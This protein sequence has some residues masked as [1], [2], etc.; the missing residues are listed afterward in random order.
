MT[1]QCV[2]LRTVLNISL[3]R[4]LLVDTL[5]SNA[6]CAPWMAAT[7]SLR[8]LPRLFCCA[9]RRLAPREPAERRQCKACAADAE[10]PAD[11]VQR[12][13]QLQAAGGRSHMLPCI[14]A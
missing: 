13:R 3:L 5:A 9:V 10:Q 8:F 14:V 6:V 4:A 2:V 12:V 1:S 7:L 11:V